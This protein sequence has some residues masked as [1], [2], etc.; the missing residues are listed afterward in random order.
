MIRRSLIVLVA[1]LLAGCAASGLLYQPANSPPKDFA[2]VYIYR[3][4]ALAY[5]ARAAHIFV[6]ERHVLN[7]NSNGYSYFYIKSG[8]YRLRQK[9]P[10]LIGGYDDGE[11]NIP[12]SVQAGET[13]FYRFN[14]W[15]SK[16]KGIPPPGVAVALKIHWQLSEMAYSQGTAE[17]VQTKL[18]QAQIKELK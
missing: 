2:L 11:L 16:S 15:V 14:T 13:Y 17:I 5:G 12:L 1:I 7:V 4:D 9:W 10:S 8:S 6:D 18:Q 3:P